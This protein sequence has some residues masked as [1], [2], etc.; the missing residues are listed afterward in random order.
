MKIENNVKASPGLFKLPDFLIDDIEKPNLLTTT[1]EQLE[2]IHAK[3][4]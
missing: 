1:R 2:K 4:D 3:I